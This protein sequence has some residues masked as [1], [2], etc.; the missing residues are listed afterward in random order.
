[1][2]TAALAALP[3][4]HTT[5]AV[6]APGITRPFT[7]RTD[8][9][10]V[11]G[12]I[13]D[14]LYYHEGENI[15]KGAVL[16]RIKDP[17]TKSKKILNRFE[18]NQREEFIHDLNL[19]TSDNP[20]EALVPHLSTPLYKEELARFVHQ[21]ADQQATL[22]KAAKELEMNSSL[23]KSKVITTKEF[24]DIQVQYDKAAANYKAFEREQQ[25]NWQQDLARYSLELSQFREELNQVNT[26]AS[27]YLVKA[28]VGGT[29]QGIN[30]RYTGGLVQPNETL[31]TISPGGNLLAECYVSAKDIGL[32]KIKQQVRFQIDAFDYN[33]FGIIIGKVIAIDNDFTTIDNKPVFKVRCSFNATQLHLKNGFTGNLKKGLTLQARFVIGERTLWQLLW[34]KVDDWLNPTAPNTSI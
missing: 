21:A 33:Y 24:F 1:M 9:K 28:P 13:I 18:I 14:T 23:M 7:E 25:S 16:L 26:D 20:N 5:I 3:F 17:I 30:N 27:Y 34:D 8:V 6:T 4:V 11:I 15:I 12:G 19:L 31:C 32:L 29:L 2:V 22:K 10:P